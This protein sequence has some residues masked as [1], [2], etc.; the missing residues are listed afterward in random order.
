MTKLQEAKNTINAVFSDTTVTRTKTGENLEEL[1]D[2][3][4]D[5]LASIDDSNNEHD[6]ER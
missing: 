3:I 2:L 1:A 5:Y 6:F 4:E